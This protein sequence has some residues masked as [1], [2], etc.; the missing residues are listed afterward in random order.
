M[1]KYYIVLLKNKFVKKKMN[2]F[3]TKKMNT[4]AIHLA[5][6]MWKTD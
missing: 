5:H 3:V 6:N 2:T 1:Y 4:W